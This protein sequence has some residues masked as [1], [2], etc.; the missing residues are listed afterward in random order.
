MRGTGRT[1]AP[2][3]MREKCVKP[4]EGD[5]LVITP[6]PLKIPPVE[7]ERSKKNGGKKEHGKEKKEKKKREEGDVSDVRGNTGK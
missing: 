1:S 3:G 2:V 6:L 5:E 7:R 4:R